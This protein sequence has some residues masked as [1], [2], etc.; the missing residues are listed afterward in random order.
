MISIHVPAWGTTSNRTTQGSSYCISI[1]VPAWGT[2]LISAFGK[3]Q[4]LSISIH[5]PAWGTTFLFLGIG[6][7]ER[8]FNPRSRVGN[9]EKALSTGLILLNFNPRSRVGN[10]FQSTLKKELFT[11]FNPRSRVGNDIPCFF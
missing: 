1:H 5:V 4:I 6:G 10:D 9:D 2:T 3:T 8:D 7:S 11:Y